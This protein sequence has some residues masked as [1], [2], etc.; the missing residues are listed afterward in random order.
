MC[1]QVAVSGDSSLGEPGA[2]KPRTSNGT[3]N[4]DVESSPKPAAKP[5]TSKDYYF[6]SYSHFGMQSQCQFNNQCTWFGGL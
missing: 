5:K 6:D 2:K 1:V 3:S 4:G